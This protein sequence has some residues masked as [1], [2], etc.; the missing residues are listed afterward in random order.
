MKSIYILGLSFILLF[1]ACSVKSSVVSHTPLLERGTPKNVELFV[2]AFEDQRKNKET[3]TTYRI[4]GIPVAWVK[5]PEGFSE[6]ITDAFKTELRHAGYRILD[7]SDQA[8]YRLEGKILRF[9]QNYGMSA[10]GHSGVEIALFD[11]SEL[12]FQKVYESKVS[13]FLGSDHQGAVAFQ[14]I[15]RELM[16]DLELQLENRR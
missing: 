8:R 6:G 13:H 10:S 9:T 12:L 14:H 1:T 4:Y 5:S 3:I 11:Q 16:E 15:L 2:G 7:Q